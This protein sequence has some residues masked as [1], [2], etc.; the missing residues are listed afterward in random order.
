[1][2]EHARLFFNYRIHVLYTVHFQSRA[3]Y[4]GVHAKY[5]VYVLHYE[6]MHFCSYTLVAHTGKA[7]SVRLRCMTLVHKSR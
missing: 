3:R 2:Q 5:I 6:N 1:M 4:F 7:N